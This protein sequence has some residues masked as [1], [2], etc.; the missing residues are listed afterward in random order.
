MPSSKSYEPKTKRETREKNAA[1]CRRNHEHNRGFWGV[2]MV[3]AGFVWL[4]KSLGWL[5]DIDVPIF[6][7][8]IIVAGVYLIIRSQDRRKDEPSS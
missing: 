2:A 8:I 7:L 1:G 3:V 4:A 5:H 6:P